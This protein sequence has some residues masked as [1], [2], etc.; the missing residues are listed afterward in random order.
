MH[1]IIRYPWNSSTTLEL[2][3]RGWK[4][5]AA[6]GSWCGPCI[7]WVCATWFV[8]A[9]ATAARELEMTWSWCH[10][11]VATAYVYPGICLLA[12]VV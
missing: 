2:Q 10:L 1:P 5:K 4:G 7:C 9:V 11:K 3:S 6:G 8:H 12:M